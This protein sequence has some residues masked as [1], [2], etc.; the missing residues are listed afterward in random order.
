MLCAC[1][2]ERERNEQIEQYVEDE[3]QPDRGNWMKNE[4]K[5]W[6]RYKRKIV[7]YQAE[8]LAVT[9][10]LFPFWLVIIVIV[11]IIIILL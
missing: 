3:R 8:K 5:L 1:E 4:E 7:L 6:E 10:S 11:I 9:L 2:R